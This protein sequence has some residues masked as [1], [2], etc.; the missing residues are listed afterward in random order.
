MMIQRH[1]CRIRSIRWTACRRAIGGQPTAPSRANRLQAHFQAAP[2][3]QKSRH[4]TIAY[5][6][7]GRSAPVPAMPPARSGR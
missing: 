1:P 5:R 2:R 7:F 6:I 3:Q 4:V